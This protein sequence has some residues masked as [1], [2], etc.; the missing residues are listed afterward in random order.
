MSFVDHSLLYQRSRLRFN[1]L[2]QFCYMFFFYAIGV[3]EAN[4]VEPA[5]DKQSFE[6]TPVLARLENRLIVYQKDYWFVDFSLVVF[7]VKKDFQTT[8]YM[9]YFLQG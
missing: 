6:R 4:F 9:R 5:H 2:V 1:N 7:G 3:L 8:N